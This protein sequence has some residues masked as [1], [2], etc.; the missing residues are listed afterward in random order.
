MSGDREARFREPKPV[1]EEREL[2]EKAIPYSAKYKNKWAVTIFGEW[3]IS[4]SVIAPVL[5]P[6]GLFKGYDLHKVAQLPT[7][8]EEMDAVILNCW[9]RK[10]VMEVD[11]KSG[12]RYPP[13]TIYGIVCGIRRYQGQ[14]LK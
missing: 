14:L 7:S 3:K 9:L 8:I 11:K 5:D 4:L 1:Y 10:F 6:G 13:R 2:V 12:E